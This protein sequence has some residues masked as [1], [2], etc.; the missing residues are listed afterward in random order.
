MLRVEASRGGEDGSVAVVLSAEPR[1]A[2]PALPDWWPLTVQERATVT[3]A[4]Q[5]LRNRQ[6]G[7]RLG[8]TEN[9]VQTHL[10]HAYDKL[11]V[12]GRGG[13][14]AR[15]FRDAMWPDFPRPEPARDDHPSWFE[16]FD[17]A[18]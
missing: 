9:T 6:I 2:V 11:M 5:G 7:A 17:A 8:V 1:P 16:V 15:F 13:L 12:T 4:V 14:L 10:T 3:L 18:D